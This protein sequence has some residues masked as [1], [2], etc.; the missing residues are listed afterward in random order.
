MVESDK[1]SGGIG[2]C[3]LLA[4]VF[5]TLKLVKA[6]GWPWIWVLSPIWIPAVIGLAIAI[7]WIIAVLVKAMKRK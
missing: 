4:I 5:I 3:G 2:L 7:V 1:T 6:I